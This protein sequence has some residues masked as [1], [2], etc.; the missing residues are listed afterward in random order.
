MKKL[1]YKIDVNSSAEKAYTTMLGL[2]N[3]DTYQQWTGEFNPTST[4]EG[5]WEKDSKIHFMGTDENGQIGGMVSLIAENIPN[6]FV[7][8][9]HVG[10]LSGDD[11]ILEG[12]EVEQWTGGFEN[13]SFEE[14]DHKT[15]I[16]VDVDVA[17]S[18]LDYFEET[19][20]KALKKL[21][22][23]IENS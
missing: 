17:E 20:P 1:H 6:K 8:I 5:S 12:P 14:S 7:S 11:E 2:E 19:Y 3:K 4:F 18:H 23:I 16:T 21:K 22:E 9:Q 15:T 10:V 13:Y